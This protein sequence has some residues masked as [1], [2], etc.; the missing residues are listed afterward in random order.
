M[1]QLKQLLKKNVRKI[2]PSATFSIVTPNDIHVGC[3]GNTNIDKLYDLAS[4]TKVIVTNTLIG[5]ALEENKLSLDDK[6]S[7][8]L[9][10]YK[11]LDII[12]DI[13]SPITIKEL[14]THRSALKVDNIKDELK[15]LSKQGYDI[16]S[17]R[18]RQNLKNIKID[19][20]LIKIINNE[21]VK[22]VSYANI[23]FILLKEL[24][25]EIYD[26]PF[27]LLAKQKIF[28][29]LNMESTHF[30][31]IADDI[32][33][34]K[35]AETENTDYRGL[36]KG[37]VH[38]ENAFFLGGVSGNAGLFSN[39]KDISKFVQM[40]LNNGRV[41]NKKF[42]SKKIIDNWFRPYNNKRTLGWEY[43]DNNI[44]KHTGFTGTCIFIN[45][46]K[47][48]ALVILTNRINYDSENEKIYDLFDEIYK[49][50][51]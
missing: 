28:E 15:E 25:E 12:N 6:L 51:S 26:I 39:I 31:K 3:V 35:Y 44:I 5:F 45:R 34:S 29:P 48:I 46:N 42:L 10:E 21:I 4:L 40:I 22:E 17:E 43:Y 7:N 18:C 14:L 33:T 38:D 16:A 32:D 41:D 23:N 49:L 9:L 19:M 30:N 36:V 2:Y 8:Y 1:M 11:Y 50:Y 27:N 24:L 20:N 37:Y 47:N 13:Y